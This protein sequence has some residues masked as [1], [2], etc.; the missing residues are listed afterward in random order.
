MTQNRAGQ[1]IYGRVYRL[2]DDRY[3]SCLEGDRSLAAGGPRD[4]HA[5]DIG[6]DWTPETMDLVTGQVYKDN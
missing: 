6:R 1:G 3:T 2:V 5:I 4:L